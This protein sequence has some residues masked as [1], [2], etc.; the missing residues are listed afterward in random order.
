M[1][2]FELGWMWTSLLDAPP[3]QRVRL[4]E[5]ASLHTMVLVSAGAL[6]AAEHTAAPA[7][8]TIGTHVGLL[9]SFEMDGVT[10]MPPAEKG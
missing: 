7:G 2:V 9:G 4:I 5:A 6:Y 3:E 1:R 8:Q 10:V